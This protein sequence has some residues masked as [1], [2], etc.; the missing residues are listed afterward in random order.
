MK[1]NFDQSGIKS[2]QQF[3]SAMET[4]HN[5]RKKEIR[6]TPLGKGILIGAG[7]LTS[8]GVV[9]GGA[10]IADA[11]TPDFRFS[12][13]THGVTVSPGEGEY[14]L[15]NRS[16]EN[17]GK[18]SLSAAK[19]HIQNLPSNA[20]VYENGQLDAGESVDVPDQVVEE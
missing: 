1:T 4:K 17:I 12:E 6:L 19:D 2:H 5:D 16:V 3:I 7:V 18:V 8:L 20:D 15:L 11:V 10:K 13:Q 9:V 14:S